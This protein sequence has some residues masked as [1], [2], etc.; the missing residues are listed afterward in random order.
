MKAIGNESFIAKVMKKI[1]KTLFRE[2]SHVVALSEDMKKYI[3]NNRSI[4]PE[5]VSVIHNWATEELGC[6]EIQSTI[7]KNIRTKYGL[8]VSYF[9]NMG[10]A[11][12]INTILEIIKDERI[13]ESNICFLFAGHGNKREKIEE[14][15]K[16][17]QLSNSIMFDYLS[18]VD[19][20]D[21][22]NITDVFLVSLEK[23]ISGLAVPSKTYSYYQSGKP[24]IAI[25]DK[26]TDVS[27][28]IYKNNAGLAIENGEIE[29]LVEWLISL[30]ND[31]TQ[32]TTMSMN[33]Q[34]MFKDS[35]T[36]DLLLEK[37]VDLVNLVLEE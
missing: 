3:L 9:G 1:N 11:Q 29:P 36:K 14:L 25:M 35:Y 21:A 7:F 27:K 28:E 23:D 6:S 34:K 17:K 13:R 16:Q 20:E 18:G 10:T 2:V 4:P 15:I 5:K 30:E 12:D 33:V 31:K 26:N 22:L 24:V 37:Y 8:V 32:L 19:F